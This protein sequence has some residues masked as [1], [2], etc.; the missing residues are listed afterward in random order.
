MGTAT[1]NTFAEMISRSL[2]RRTHPLTRGPAAT[3]RRWV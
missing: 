2:G 1:V 3:I